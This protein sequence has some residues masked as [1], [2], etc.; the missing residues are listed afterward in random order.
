MGVRNMRYIELPEKL[1]ILFETILEYKIL[2]FLVAF[3]IVFTFLLL[4][5]AISRK[6][7]I[8]LVTITF[9]IGL[10]VTVITTSDI[11]ISFNTK[12]ICSFVK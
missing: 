7:Y 9:L 5:K 1:I 3:L 8:L 11:T 6:T 2:V 10:G 12:N 4:K